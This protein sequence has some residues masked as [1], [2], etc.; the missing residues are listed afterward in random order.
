[1]NTTATLQQLKDLKLSGMV[2]SYE[3]VLQ[4]STHQQ[5]EAHTM[6]AQL[7]DAEQQSR[8]HHKTLFFLKLSKLRYAAMLEEISYTK[9]RNLT[10]D[11]THIKYNGLNSKQRER[12]NFQKIAGLLAD[13]GYSSI[14]LDDDWQGADFIAQHIDGNTFIKIQ[15][16]SRLTFDRKYLGK[17]IFIAFPYL[18]SW[19]LFDHDELLNIFLVTFSTSM[20]T[21]PSWTMKGGYSWPA[22][23]KKGLEILERYKLIPLGN[24]I[25]IEEEE[26]EEIG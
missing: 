12:Y 10:R 21:S 23:S 20:A 4:L 2:R 18:D 11:L 19:Y 13:Y 22:P 15:L 8:V 24:S 9:D 7:C 25:E 16:K 26:Q 14:K 5:P 6:I 1:M 17:N 3:S